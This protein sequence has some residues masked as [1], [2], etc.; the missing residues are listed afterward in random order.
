M[1]RSEHRTGVLVAF[2]GV[3]GGVPGGYVWHQGIK[4][5]GGSCVEVAR[6]DESVIMRSTVNPDVTLTVNRD[7]WREFLA[8]AKVGCFDE[9]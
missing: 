8:G 3:V 1:L 2:G 6:I 4:C 9:L 7:E 5:D